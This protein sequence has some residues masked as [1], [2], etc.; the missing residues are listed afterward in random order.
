MQSY[1][2][3]ACIE[4]QCRRRLDSLEPAKAQR[5]CKSRNARY[6]CDR[7]RFVHSRLKRKSRLR[8]LQCW[9]SARFFGIAS[10]TRGCKSLRR[11][12]KARFQCC[13]CPSSAGMHGK[14]I[15]IE[16]E[17]VPTPTSPNTTSIWIRSTNTLIM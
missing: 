13:R 16:F 4:L 7:S 8:E 1:E 15:M 6:E 3:A 10:L 2:Q 17:P 5:A 14:L 12:E 9:F 11:Q